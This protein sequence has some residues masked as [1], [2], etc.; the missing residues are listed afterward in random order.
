MSLHRWR[1]HALRKRKQEEDQVYWLGEELGI[2]GIRNSAWDLLHLQSSE[3]VG[4]VGLQS[5]GSRVDFGEA[6]LSEESVL[7]VMSR[8]PRLEHEHFKRKATG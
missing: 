7:R 5:W 8:Q 3:A 4:S 1:F 2:R 6:V